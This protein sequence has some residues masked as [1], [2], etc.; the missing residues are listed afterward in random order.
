MTINNRLSLALKISTD[1]TKT[2]L[3]ELGGLTKIG[4]HLKKDCLEDENLRKN[5]WK[6]LLKNSGAAAM[7]IEVDGIF[8]D[9]YSEHLIR[10]YAFENKIIFVQILFENNDSLCGDF[11]IT[12]YQRYGDAENEKY[13]LVLISSGEVRYINEASNNVLAIDYK[14]PHF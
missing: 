3:V 11:F 10:L 4:F 6:H 14:N 13:H 1:G 2:N 9:Q 12:D 5:K 7:E 8:T